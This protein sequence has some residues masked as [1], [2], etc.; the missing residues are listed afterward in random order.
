MSTRRFGVVG[1]AMFATVGIALTGCSSTGAGGNAAKPST[2]SPTPTL[3][4]P[5]DTL[6]TAIK[7]LGQTSYTFTV[8]QATVSG[9]G[10]ADPAAKAAQ[11][12]I[13]AST[14]G[15]SAKMSIVSLGSDNW[16]QMDFG[17]ALD[18]QAG[19]DPTKWM[20]IDTSKVTK[21]DALPVD[22]ASPDLLDFSSI[23]NAVLTVQRVDATH[24]SG[25]IDLTT[26]KGPAEP[27][28]ATLSKVAD[29]AKS[30]PF[31]ATLDGNGRPSELKTDGSGID[32]GLSLDI[33]F[34]DYGAHQN[35]SKPT[36]TIA[37][38]PST[39]YSILNG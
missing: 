3:A 14:S 37:D 34:S 36:G 18:Q 27:D 2:P 33:T 8:K 6:V 38:A 30:V 31:T 20:H 24:Y 22:P 15:V 39:V 29:K 35:I 32:P 11:V 13:A 21:A 4:A 12:S 23:T 16:T 25:T 26:V 7:Q 9:Q 28:S 1:V 19:I 10:K 5:K 17:P